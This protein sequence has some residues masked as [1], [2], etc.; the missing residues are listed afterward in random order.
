MEH[1]PLIEKLLALKQADF[2]GCKDDL[3]TCP[4][5]IKWRE[6]L[7]RMQE[8]NVPFSL[9]E[10]AVNG[11]DLQNEGFPNQEIGKLLQKLLLHTACL[12]CD[13][14]KPKLLKLAKTF[15]KEGL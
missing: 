1:Y 14:Q 10:L 9:K 3:S 5:E 15:Y 6:I 2:S 4:T 8:E 7:K 13:N 12:P 11:K